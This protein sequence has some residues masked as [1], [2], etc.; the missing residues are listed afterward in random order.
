M[1]PIELFSRSN[2][3]WISH[4]WIFLLTAGCVYPEFEKGHQLCDADALV[5]SCT[6]AEN[7]DNQCA[8]PQETYCQDLGFFGRCATKCRADTDCEEGELCSQGICYEVCGVNTSANDCN[9]TPGG[10]SYPCNV[11]VCQPQEGSCVTREGAD[12]KYR[13]SFHN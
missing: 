2:R 11:V 13:C 4:I 10:G 9:G 12:V 1:Y 8:C 5:N 3:K 7:D 6:Y